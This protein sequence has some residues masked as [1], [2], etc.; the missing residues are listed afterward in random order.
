MEF[1]ARLE[2]NGFTGRDAYLGAGTRVATNACFTGLHIEDSETA[3]FDA[4][5]RSERVL[6]SFKDRIDSGFC[7]DAR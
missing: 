2:A 1:F 3:E 6:H 5:A 7:L 4:I